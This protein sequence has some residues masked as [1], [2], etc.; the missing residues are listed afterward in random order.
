MKAIDQTW[1]VF[2][3]PD[4]SILGLPSGPGRNGVQYLDIV[5]GWQGRRWVWPAV[6][7]GPRRDRPK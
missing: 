2:L 4:Y 6:E 1:T 5:T 3:D 7:A